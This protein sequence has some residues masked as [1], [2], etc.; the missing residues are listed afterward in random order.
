MRNAIVIL[1]HRMTKHNEIETILEELSLAGCNME[2]SF[3]KK[4]IL[5]ITEAYK[6]LNQAEKLYFNHQC[7]F[8]SK[9][10]LIT[11][12]IYN[13]PVAGIAMNSELTIRPT[14]AHSATA[15]DRFLDKLTI[16]ENRANHADPV[17]ILNKPQNASSN[18]Q[19][20]A[21]EPAILFPSANKQ[22]TEA[23][24]DNQVFKCTVLSIHRNHISVKLR[25]PQ[26]HHTLFDQYDYWAIL[27]ENPE[28]G[29]QAMYQNLSEWMS[30]PK[31]YRDM[32]LGN[33]RPV[34][35]MKSLLPSFRIL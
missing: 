20:K 17:L 8:I 29:Y 30:A 6:N 25:K 14:I 1:D 4:D 10:K 9:E 21:G 31:K 22:L 34:F 23:V 24:F 33:R 35:W 11:K 18:P 5:Q 3:L 26:H 27:T 19:I 15:E 13:A 12:S 7:A 32:I 28:N 16:L 2:N